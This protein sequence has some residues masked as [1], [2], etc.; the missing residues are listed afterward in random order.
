[1]WVR[2][3]TANKMLCMILEDCPFCTLSH[4]PLHSPGETG[5]DNRRAGY[6]WPFLTEGSWGGSRSDD[7]PQHNVHTHHTVV[8]HTF[9]WTARSP[10]PQSPPHSSL[11]SK[12]YIIKRRVRRGPSPF[13]SSRRLPSCH[14]RACASFAPGSLALPALQQSLRPVRSSRLT[15]SPLA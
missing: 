1:M 15:L 4:T 6:H 13:P 3:L 14:G 12:T 8:P 7:E 9:T 11:E 5:L 2:T 10:G